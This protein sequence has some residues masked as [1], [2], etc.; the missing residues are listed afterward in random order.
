MD[1][2]VGSVRRVTDIMAEIMAATD[3]QTAGIN[4]INHAISQMD[5]VT[6]QNAALVEEAAAASASMQEQ[7]EQL[8]QVVSV[9]KVSAAAKAAPAAVSHANVH[10][11][12]IRPPAPRR[13]VAALPRASAKVANKPATVGADDDWEQF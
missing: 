12:G 3:E 10:R 2:I 9:F 7:A 13:A 11:P 4:E 1:E 8:A 6:Q 5:Q